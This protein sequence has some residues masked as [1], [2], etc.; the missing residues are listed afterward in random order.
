MSFKKILQD[1]LIS[2]GSRVLYCN[3]IYNVLELRLTRLNCY[4]FST[5]VS[6]N[7]WKTLAL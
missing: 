1:I 7:C 5:S 4:T 3:F 2:T 6:E